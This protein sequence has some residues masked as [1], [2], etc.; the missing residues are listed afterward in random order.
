MASVGL[1]V[2]WWLFGGLTVYA[3][4]CE[5]DAPDGWK[6]VLTFFWPASIPFIGMAGVIVY[7]S[8]VLEGKIK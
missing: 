6:E 3:L 7:C 4:L 5:A 8:S 1:L 2:L